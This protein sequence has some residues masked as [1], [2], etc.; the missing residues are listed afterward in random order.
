MPAAQSQLRM[1]Q[2]SPEVTRARPVEGVA[3]GVQGRPLVKSAK[4][5]AGRF[6][7]RKNSHC[8]TMAA[9]EH[10][11]L[12]NPLTLKGSH[13]SLGSAN[14]FTFTLISLFFW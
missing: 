1:M 8:V 9:S 11:K 5:T 2:W 14:V 4:I 3:V 6:A 12:A 10:S 7:N 13:S